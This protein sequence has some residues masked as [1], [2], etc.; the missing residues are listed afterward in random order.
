ME[1]GW[2]GLRR[3]LAGP[4]A[5]IRSRALRQP[6][7]PAM[8]QADPAQGVS[9]P[10]SWTGVCLHEAKGAPALRV[11]ASLRDGR[12][13]LQAADQ[14]GVPVASVGAMTVRPVDPGL[15]RGRGTEPDALFSLGWTELE[16]PGAGERAN[17]VEVFECISPPGT[18]PVQ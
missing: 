15:L 18:D 3:G 17:E 9:L 11:R 7:P 12:F 13:A 8:L 1:A 4:R 2:G 16:L 10:F 14:D 5:G 6:P